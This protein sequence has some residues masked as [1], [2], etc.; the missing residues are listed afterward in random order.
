MISLPEL[1]GKSSYNVAQHRQLKGLIHALSLP[2][3]GN[4]SWIFLVDDDTWINTRELSIFLYGW[5]PDVPILFGHIYKN[6]LFS[7]EKRTW[8]SG[9]AGMLLS[10]AAA[11]L[12]ASSLYTSECPFDSLNDLTIG[13]CSWRVGI[14]LSH[15]Q[16]FN[17]TA[18]HVIRGPRFY[19]DDSN[20]KSEI[21]VHTA[22]PTLM[23][24]LE[25]LF[26]FNVNHPSKCV[27]RTELDKG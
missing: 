19:C 24:E 13:Y 11:V 7:K 27:K 22:T 3:N 23:I 10:R 8:P 5:N 2:E 18:E 16:L 14:A 12:L 15:S 4:F 21:S 17:P 20:L 6:A 1:E 26:N 9:G 25:V